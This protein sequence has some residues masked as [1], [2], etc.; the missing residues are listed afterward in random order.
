MTMA[1]K[2]EH[3]AVELPHVSA[4]Q[5]HPVV[6]GVDDSSGSAAAVEWAA[7]EAITRGVPLRIVHTWAWQMLEPWP[8]RV[9]RMAVADLKRDGRTILD[10]SLQQV[11]KHVGLEVSADVVEGY[12]PDVLAEAGEDASVLVLGSHQLNVLGRAVLGSVSNAVVSRAMCPVVV[13][14][15]PS[16]LADE[17]PTVVAGVACEEQDEPVLAY[18]FE[19]AQR[20]DLPLK[21]M[22]CWHPP[23]ADTTLP[24]P[25]QARLQLA[26]S[27]AGWREQYP[28][29]EVHTTVRR[30]HPVDALVHASASQ[31]LLVVGRH[32]RRMRF[33]TLLGSVSLGVLH[34]AT[35]PVAII[36]PPPEEE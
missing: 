1:P 33:G 36:P 13:V 24:P 25:E 3:E 30:A 6:V 10:R 28:D 8:S 20:K 7:V 22:L 12:P 2:V 18:A 27:V 29:V 4:T 26:E 32:A 23:F 17:R 11:K 16:G 21:V 15:A 9:D 35:C 5:R 34:H 31:E 14:C 19:H